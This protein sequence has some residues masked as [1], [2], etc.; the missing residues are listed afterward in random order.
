MSIRIS[1][2]HVA[3]AAG[4]SISTVSQ[5]LRGDGRISAAT[6][7]SVEEV[8]RKLGYQRDPL[9]SQFASRKFHRDDRLNGATLLFVTA[10]QQEAQRSLPMYF[11]VFQERTERLGFRFEH[12]EMPLE[13]NYEKLLKQWFYRGVRG[14]AFANVFRCQWLLEEPVSRFAVVC[15]GG[16]MRKLT[17]HTVKAEVSTA[18]I[19]MWEKAREHGYKRIGFALCRHA[20]E[21]LDDK[22]RLGIAREL[23]VRAKSRIPV[24]GGLMDNPSDFKTWMEKYRPDAVIGFPGQI[25]SWAEQSSLKIPEDCALLLAAIQPNDFFSGWVENEAAIANRAADLLDSMIFHGDTEQPS[26]PTVTLVSGSWHEGKSSPYVHGAKPLPIM[27]V[28]R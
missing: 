26:P 6:R 1:L 20:F 15:I 27:P 19:G 16:S 23:S 13:F 2:K 28:L 8:A 14:I 18:V 17:Y 22:L 10:R 3:E 11:N 25:A 7:K 9:L 21:T 5:A 12:F 4:V 24:Y